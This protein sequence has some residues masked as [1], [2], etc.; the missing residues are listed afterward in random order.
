ML[1]ALALGVLIGAED[2]DAR[3]DGGLSFGKSGGRTFAS[4][5]V[6]LTAS[7]DVAALDDPMLVYAGQPT[8]PGGKLG[9]LFNRP[10]FV[11]GFAAGFLGAGVLGVLFGHGMLGELSGVASCLGL[12]F[13]LILIGMLTRLIWS[14]W[15]AGKG[16][17]FAGLSPRQ[18]ADA[19][20][21]SRN[22]ALPDIDTG[23]SADA[24]LGEAE[25]DAFKNRDRP[26]R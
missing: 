17:P 14:R 25:N 3:L 9:G 26:R 15:H 7:D 13:Q 6:T 23:A 8:Y 1:A 22:E 19:Y 21:R 2:A 18:L 10:G 20:G 16:A 11:G 4:S 12:I 5:P 24:A